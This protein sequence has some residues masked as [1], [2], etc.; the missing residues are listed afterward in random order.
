MSDPLEAK[1]DEL[2][3]HHSTGVFTLENQ[4]SIKAS[5]TVDV[6]VTTTDGTNSVQDTVAG[7][8]INKVCDSSSTTLLA[9]ALGMLRQIPNYPTPPEITSSFTSSNPACP[10]TTH[11]LLS[12]NDHF[13]LTDDESTFTVTMTDKANSIDT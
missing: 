9:P 11:T 5:Y 6:I 2:T 10:V 8:T 12:S 1:P 13:T 3:I 4:A 7:I